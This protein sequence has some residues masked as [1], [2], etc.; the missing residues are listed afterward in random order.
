MSR[1]GLVAGAGDLPIIF[2]KEAKQ[3]GDTVIGFGLKG[4]T[5]EDLAD[6]VDKMHWLEWGDFKKGVLLLAT[7]RIKKIAMLGK[8]RKDLFF[9]NDAGL[10]DKAKELLRSTQDKKD[11]SIL[12]KVQGFL[13]TFGIE[14]I[15]PTVYLSSLISVK[16]TLSQRSP[17]ENE[18]ADISYAKDVAA[19][20]AGYD[21]GQTVVVKDKTVIAIEAVEGTDDTI[22]RAG[23]LTGGG[24]VVV[25]MAR[26]DQDMRFD[27]PL[28]GLDTLSTIVEN[29][30]KVL[31]LE[32]KRTFLMDKDDMIKLADENGISIVVV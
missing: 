4:V 8:I 31:A 25:K 27:I 3:K 10:D 17:T 16:G 14:T 29:K 15:D 32:E 11:Y 30:G 26:P 7:E 24:F 6:H 9:K 19:K 12:N 23:S 20:I 1:I 2:S 18:W 22:K 5:S 13:G 28:V 21:I